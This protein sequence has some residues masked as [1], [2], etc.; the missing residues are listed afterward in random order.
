MVQ[1]VTVEDGRITEFRPF[2]WNVAEY[3]AVTSEESGSSETRA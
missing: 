2:Y 1:V 3:V